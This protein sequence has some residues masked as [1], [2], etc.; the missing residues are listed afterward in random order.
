MIGNNQIGNVMYGT[1]KIYGQGYDPTD[2]TN[3]VKIFQAGKPEEGT[4]SQ[5][6][7]EGNASQSGVVGS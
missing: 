2:P 5:H 1:D 7:A 4:S 6:N 3:E